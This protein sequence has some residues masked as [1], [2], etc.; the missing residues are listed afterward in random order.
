MG[1][2]NVDVISENTGNYAG[3]IGINLQTPVVLGRNS[4]REERSTIKSM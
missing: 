4:Y 2:E 3:S 1:S